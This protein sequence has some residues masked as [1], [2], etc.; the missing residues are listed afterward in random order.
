MQGLSGGSSPLLFE[1]V[2]SEAQLYPV[3][4]G[5]PHAEVRVRDVR[6]PNTN[7]ESLAF[8]RSYVNPSTPFRRKIEAGRIA[9]RQIHRRAHTS[10][11]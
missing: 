4:L 5:I 11:R 8:S 9:R 6:P 2:I 7:V 1:P 3:K 10:S